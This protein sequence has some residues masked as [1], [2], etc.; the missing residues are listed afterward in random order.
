M[1]ETMEPGFVTGAS[2]KSDIWSTWFVGTNT[3]LFATWLASGMLSVGISV[4]VEREEYFH[5][6]SPW[7]RNIP[8][9]AFIACFILG[10]IFDAKRR[11]ISGIIELI[12]ASIWLAAHILYTAHLDG[13]G[14]LAD[15]PTIMLWLVA[16]AG[17]AFV[18]ALAVRWYLVRAFVVLGKPEPAATSSEVVPL[19]RKSAEPETKETEP[20]LTSRL[21][22]AGIHAGGY[23]F[24]R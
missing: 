2:R 16:S 22:V 1:H 10:A 5:A 8:S 7:L 15:Q 21:P 13:D 12:L 9:M 19:T 11:L 24:R 6:V 3:P 17:T 14:A 23:S 18:S 20:T 4:A